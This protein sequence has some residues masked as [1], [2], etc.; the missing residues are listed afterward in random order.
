MPRSN[1]VGTKAA[2]QAI[3]AETGGGFFGAPEKPKA[4]PSDGQPSILE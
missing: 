2:S 4:E 1:P 3:A